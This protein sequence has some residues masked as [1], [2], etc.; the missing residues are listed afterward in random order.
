MAAYFCEQTGKR[1]VAPGVCKD[2]DPINGQDEFSEQ[3][4]EA[5][6]PVVAPEA[7]AQPA[8]VADAPPPHADKSEKLELKPSQPGKSGK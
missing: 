6:A 8:I 1:I 7:P 2:I 5:P 4:I 3:P